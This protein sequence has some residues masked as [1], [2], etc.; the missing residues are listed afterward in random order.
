MNIVQ[1]YN[2]QIYSISRGKKIIEKINHVYLTYVIQVN[3]NTLYSSLDRTKV[4][5]FE[6]RIDLLHVMVVQKTE[7]CIISQ[8][9]KNKNLNF[10]TVAPSAMRNYCQAYFRT[11]NYCVHASRC[12][13]SGEDR[14]TGVC[15]KPRTKRRLWKMYVR[16]SGLYCS[17]SLRLIILRHPNAGKATNR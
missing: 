11:R 10:R 12:V 15:T 1:W 13:K 5:T 3:R 6:L 8:K 17:V 2:F 7:S 14:Q 4:H 9:L 16:F